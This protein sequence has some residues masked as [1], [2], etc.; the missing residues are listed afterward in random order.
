VKEQESIRAKSHA[1]G[2]VTLQEGQGNPLA[3]MK[4]EL[5]EI[6]AEFEAGSA[7]EIVFSVRGVPVV[8]DAKKQEL[9]VNGTRAPAPL[10]EGKQRLRSSRIALAWRCLRATGLPTCRCRS[11]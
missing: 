6:D 2:A 4:G 3:Q 10:R 9:T 1:V 11:I 7:G 5:F 8:Y